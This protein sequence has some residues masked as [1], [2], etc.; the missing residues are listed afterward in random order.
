MH[1][2]RR[3]GSRAPP[4]RRP[5]GCPEPG[6]PS[7]SGRGLLAGRNRMSAAPQ[8]RVLL[9]VLTECTSGKGNTY[10]RGWAGASNLVAF[11][12]DDD[13]VG[14][15]TWS[16]FLVQRQPRE[17]AP[18]PARGLRTGKRTS[19]RTSKPSGA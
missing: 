8:A 13:E 9:A 18:A 3:Q 2:L 16:L 1:A 11:R 17:G 7:R 4:G 15:P 6:R 12:G 19:P 14:R 10:L 5:P